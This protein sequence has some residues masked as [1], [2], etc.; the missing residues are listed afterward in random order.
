MLYWVL[1][2]KNKSLFSKTF[3]AT[4]SIHILTLT[5]NTYLVRIQLI[6]RTLELNIAKR[7][8][9]LYKTMVMPCLARGIRP[10]KVYK[11]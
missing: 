1:F 10:K 6:V 7:Q 5:Q 9:F 11:I 3:L 8:C 2:N 4:G